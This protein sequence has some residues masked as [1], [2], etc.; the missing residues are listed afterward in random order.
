LE[1][2][3]VFTGEGSRDPSPGMRR[4]FYKNFLF[5]H[6]GE[7]S[8]YKAIVLYLKPDY[9]NSLL[10][11]NRDLVGFVVERAT[12]KVAKT[13][14]V[15]RNSLGT[16]YHDNRAAYAEDKFDLLVGSI[17]IIGV[18]SGADMKEVDKKGTGI[19]RDPLAYRVN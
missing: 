3:V 10:D 8:L 4:I 7:T 18:L 19:A 15:E 14:I 16:W 6:K 1:F 5:K 12:G 17:S 9:E 2:H 11:R 13:S